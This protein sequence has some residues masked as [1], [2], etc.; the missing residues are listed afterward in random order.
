MK[1]LINVH[2]KKYLENLNAFNEGF[3]PLLTEFLGVY[4]GLQMFVA[5]Y[6][7]QM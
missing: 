2:C 5:Q 3:Y 7:Y 6:S 4:S 1:I